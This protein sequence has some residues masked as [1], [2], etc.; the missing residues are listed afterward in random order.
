MPELISDMTSNFLSRPI[1]VSKYGL[2]YAGSQKNYGP[3]GLTIVIVK[4]KL[5]AETSEMPGLPS[6]LSYR[7]ILK[8][9]AERHT[10]P[11]TFALLFTY[12]FLKYM[13][14]MGG[15]KAID[16]IAR[17]K[18]QK[19]YNV[20][21]ESNGFYKSTV[22]EEFRSRMNVPFLILNDDKELT[23][24]FLKESGEQGLLQLKGHKSVGGLRAS[25]YNGMPMEGVDRLC[26]F[27]RDFQKRYHMK[28][29]L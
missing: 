14:D 12:E 15:L 29:K 3:P 27:M 21:N 26:Q 23:K 8:S 22:D 5:L 1:D 20:M 7:H 2:I 18:S 9:Q 16:K 11:P 25:V 4:N 17:A 6:Q 13:K 28:P 10:V 19:L 24:K